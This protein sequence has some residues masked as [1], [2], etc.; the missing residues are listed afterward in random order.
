MSSIEDLPE[1]IRPDSQI[2][3]VYALLG[4]ADATFRWLNIAIREHRIGPNF[5]RH[6]RAL[7]PY[8]DTAR[9]SELLRRLHLDPSDA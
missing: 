6:N 7:A 2:V 8:R 4:D 5:L 1:P 3:T 9:F